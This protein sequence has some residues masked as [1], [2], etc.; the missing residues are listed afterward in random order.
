MLLRAD[1]VLAVTDLERSATRFVEVLGCSGVDAEPGNWVRC[2]CRVVTCMLGHAPDA[3]PA[4]EL[5]DHS[6]NAYLTVDTVADVFSR[7]QES[8]PEVLRPPA[9][10]PQGP[11]EVGLRTPAGHRVMLGE[12]R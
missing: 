8:H 12:R 10:E 11:R 3:C 2:T 6:S 1:P 4:S 7:T 9:E 5:G